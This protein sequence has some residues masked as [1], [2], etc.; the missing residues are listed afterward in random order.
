M[1]SKRIKPATFPF[2]K[3]NYNIIQTQKIVQTTSLRIN[4]ITFCLS[5]HILQKFNGR[6]VW[7]GNETS[8]L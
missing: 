7:L 1:M 8:N 4:P 3:S 5:Q 6:N 2:P